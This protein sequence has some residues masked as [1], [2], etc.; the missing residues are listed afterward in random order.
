MPTKENISQFVF[1]LMS[2]ELYEQMLLN[3]EINENQLYLTD[4]Q[5][6]AI[7][8]DYLYSLSDTIVSAPNGIISLL[9]SNLS[10]NS[11]IIFDMCDGKDSDG[12]LSSLRVTSNF[13]TITLNMNVGESREFFYKSDHT[14]VNYTSANIS[15]STTQPTGVTLWKDV[16]NNTYWTISGS[17]KTKINII[18]L[19]EISRNSSG[20]SIDWSNTATNVLKYSDKTLIESWTKRNVITSAATTVVFGTNNNPPSNFVIQENTLYKLGTLTSLTLPA[21]FPDSI[22]ETTIIFY[23]GATATTLV[24]NVP[25]NKKLSPF[26]PT[27][28]NQAYE[29]SLWNGL[30]VMS[31]P[32]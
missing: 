26:K 3:G 13:V 31:S 14:V 32:S 29:I 11:D 6:P 25:A 4:D 9:G 24:D 27:V 5:T 8:E 16:A 2:K 17:T 19:A 1:N 30:W 18:K 10:V 15:Y 28:A 22:R 23:S 20:Y 21:T 7:A 12:K